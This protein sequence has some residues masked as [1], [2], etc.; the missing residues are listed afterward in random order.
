ML[1]SP[2]TPLDFGLSLLPCFR[3]RRPEMG[4]SFSFS[5]SVAY[6]GAVL[7]PS[8]WDCCPVL[9]TTSDN[10]SIP[11]LNLSTKDK[12]ESQ[13]KSGV[14][15]WTPAVHFNALIR[16]FLRIMISYTPSKLYGHSENPCKCLAGWR[17]R[18]VRT[19]RGIDAIHRNRKGSVRIYSHHRQNIYSWQ[20]CMFRLRSS[21]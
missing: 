20:A 7:L 1:W 18:K 5:I 19:V 17:V 12:F 4:L 15:F 11:T 9:W 6:G 16:A 10:A 13:H 3:R 21:Q 8:Q 2:L 14:V